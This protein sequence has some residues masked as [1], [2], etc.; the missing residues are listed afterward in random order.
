MI[1]HAVGSWLDQTLCDSKS[2]RI[3]VYRDETQMIAKELI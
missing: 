1:D 2:V 3:T